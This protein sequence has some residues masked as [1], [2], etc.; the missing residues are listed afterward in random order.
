MSD[1]PL[2]T[3]LGASSEVRRE[4][5]CAP[6][7]DGSID[8]NPQTKRENRRWRWLAYQSFLSSSLVRLGLV[9]STMQSFNPSHDDAKSIYD[10]IYS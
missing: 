8:A 10:K 4:S 2:G 9:P 7:L 3:S 6:S 5:P 1:P